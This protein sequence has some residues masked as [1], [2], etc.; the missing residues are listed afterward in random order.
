MLNMFTIAALQLQQHRRTAQFLI[1]LLHVLYLALQHR[2][3]YTTMTTGQHCKKA[4]PSLKFA[5]QAAYHD[6]MEGSP[7]RFG[8]FYRFVMHN[9]AQMIV[10]L[11]NKAA[12]KSGGLLY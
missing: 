1:V 8:L 9:H 6:E 12:L 10:T 5:L 4:V 3:A 7:P 11:H 2:Q